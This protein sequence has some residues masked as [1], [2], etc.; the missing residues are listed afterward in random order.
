MEKRLGIFKENDVSKIKDYDSNQEEEESLTVN[1]NHMFENSSK[2]GDQKEEGN[3]QPKKNKDKKDKDK[4]DKDDKD[5]KGNI[6]VRA[7]NNKLYRLCFKII[8]SKYFV[9]TVL[10]VITANTIT[11]AMD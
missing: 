5:N 6:P 8:K 4:D 2:S 7:R 1:S 9:I 3:K 10:L 11:L